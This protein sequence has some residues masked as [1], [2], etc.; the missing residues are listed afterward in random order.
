MSRLT[1]HRPTNGPAAQDG[2]HRDPLCEP[3]LGR[4]SDHRLGPLSNPSVVATEL[5]GDSGPPKSVREA[6]G[7]SEFL[8]E[9]ER[10]A[11]TF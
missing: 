6:M 9:R 10:L 2:T 3:M 7:M 1:G 8:G 11:A 4:Q 5:I